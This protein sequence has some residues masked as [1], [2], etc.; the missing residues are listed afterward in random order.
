MASIGL[1]DSELSHWRLFTNA[2]GDIRPLY[3][4]IHVSEDTYRDILAEYIIAENEY[5]DD[6]IG[7]YVIAG[8]DYYRRLLLFVPFHPKYFLLGNARTTLL[9]LL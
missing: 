3:N 5:R 8:K 4:M 7:K 1:V 9:L 2:N 6:I